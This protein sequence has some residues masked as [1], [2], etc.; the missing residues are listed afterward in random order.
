MVLLRVLALEADPGFRAPAN[1]LSCRE[2]RAWI[3]SVP[4]LANHRTQLV[5]AHVARGREDDLVGLVRA[6]VVGR[7]SAARDARDDVGASDH[8]PPER[9]RAE[10]GL[11]RDVVHEVVRRVLDHGDLLEHHL[12]LGVDVHERGSEDHV[13]HHVERPLEAV[14]RNRA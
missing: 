2:S 1:R 11:G 4:S 5:V 3:R 7:E 14:V 10:H 12:P 9:M 6:P 8:G 13:R